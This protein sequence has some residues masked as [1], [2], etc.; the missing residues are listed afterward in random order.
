MSLIG[1][2]VALCVLG[3]VYYLVTLLPLPAPFKT[4][5]QVVVILI[6]IIWLLS[7]FGLLGGNMF[8]PHADLR[9]R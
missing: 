2:L 7:N 6:C 4:I 8:G 3:L 9:V 5:A 1:I